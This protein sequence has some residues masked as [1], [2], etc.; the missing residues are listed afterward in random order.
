MRTYLALAALM[1]SATAGFA[2]GTVQDKS[3]PLPSHLPLRQEACFGRV[4]DAK[5]LASHPRQR[6]TSFHLFRDFSVDPN[7]EYLP[8]DPQS[9]LDGDGEYGRV[10]LSAYVRLRDK[11]GVFSNT[12][13]CG[14]GEKGGIS[15]AID[16]DG[17]SFKLKPA[18]SALDLTNEGFVVIGG[19]GSSEE[20][21]DNPVTV[22][23]GADDRVF[24]LMRQPLKAC[25]AEREAMKPTFAAL[26]APLRM[27]FGTT[28]P[29]CFARS[30]DAAHL[31]AHPDQQVKRI[32]VARAAT[33]A[34]EDSAGFKFSFRVERR[35]GK[36]FEK[37]AECVP[38]NY[39]YSC[40]SPDDADGAREFYLSRAGENDISLR[41]PRK[42]L[43]AMLGASLGGD[44]RSFKLTQSAENACRF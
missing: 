7:A 21:N 16:C 8:D 20:D 23:P 32:A 12:F 18:G 43:S 26:G 39:V 44:D 29:H 30:Y 6:V 9:L 3:S 24:R 14:R 35:D 25:V 41:D 37:T 34:V 17:G 2:Q 1:L 28:E 27:R 4:Y 11:K 5:H 40:T 36:T 33:G 15:C 10:N 31:A 19:C 22:Q 42:V 38:D 13:S